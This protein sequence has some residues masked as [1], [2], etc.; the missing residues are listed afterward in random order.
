MKDKRP[1]P[2]H[3]LKVVSKELEQERRGRLKIFFGA[4]AGVGKTYAMLLAARQQFE[5]GV[6]VTAGIVETHDREE[7]KRLLDGLPRLA[8]RPIVYQGHAIEEFDVDAALGAGRDLVLVDEL[9][10]A[11]PTGSRHAKRSGDV[12]DLLAAGIDVYT[13]LN[14]QHL[15]SVADIVSGIIGVRV[16]ETV[17]DRIFDDA[18]EVVLVDLP[19]DDLLARLAAG[20]VCVPVAI[21]RARE[22]FFRKGNLIALRELALQRMADRVNA[23]V[24]SYRLAKSIE[25]VWPTRERLMICVSAAGSQER[26]IAEGHRIARRL[27]ADCLVVHVQTLKESDEE[28]EYLHVLARQA[29][30]LKTEFLNVVGEDVADTLLEY[31]RANNVTKL[32]LGHGTRR[33]NRPW[34]RQLSEQIARANPEL[35][36]LLVATKPAPG[37]RKPKGPESPPALNARSIAIT[38]LACAVTTL[39]AE[40]LF[41]FFDAS[42]L[43]TLF[44]L[45]VVVVSLRLGR[46]AAVWG[47]LL[48]VACFDFFFIPPLLSFAVSDT[49]YFFTFALILVIALVTSELGSR[50]RSDARS[51]RAGERREAALARV[52]RDLSGALKSEQIV[53]ICWET[54]APLFDAKVALMLPD[55]SDRLHAT[56]TGG[57]E[58]IPVAQWAYDHVQRTGW[59]TDTLSAAEA[60]YLPLKAPIRCRGVLAIQPRDWRFLEEPD[61]KRLLEACCSSI[62]LAL[63]RIHFADVA[64]ETLVRMEGERLRNSLLSAVSH[65]LRT[66]LT[67]IRG[68]AETLETGTEL[69]PADQTDAASA[70]RHQ[71]EGLQRVVTN[72]LDLARMQSAG[73]RL[74]NEWHSLSEIVGSALSRLG[75]A[76]SQRRVSTD[77]PGDLP[78]LEV[79]ASLI[80]RVVFNLLDNAL[81]YT[82]SDTN[83]LIA[84]KAVGNSMYCFVEDNGPGLPPGDPEQFFEPFVRGKRESAISGVGLGLAL[85]RSII[86]AHGG[87]IR[88][89]AVKPSGARF[90]MRIPL[91][92]PP[93]I[94]A[95]NEENAA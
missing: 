47:A 10:H 11:N 2:D 46:T 63:E 95:E 49:Q 88:V 35:A 32:V 36:I 93:G 5:Q 33:W 4:C 60:L 80:E 83:I 15:E 19:P 59:G 73:I 82:S 89:E 84:A 72:L 20:K 45:T 18:T 1:D 64:Q 3:L 81:K 48:S 24:R 28:R 85:C 39:V 92:S 7:T 51:A 9:A 76:L 23:D 43:V 29:D 27:Q 37:K 94:E 42:N 22:N 21:D 44:L 34:R 79:D 57:F 66:P 78:L 61:E 56:R 54:M 68:L 74:N 6:K 41:R 14:V 17:P 38:T 70:I 25:A 55:A 53:T 86:A 75:P 26:L 58:D 40:G 77:L 8:L 50:L 67:A 69:S 87:T 90:E 52:A 91:G 16:R 62:A 13:T 65:D 12:E 31:A 71:A 30:A